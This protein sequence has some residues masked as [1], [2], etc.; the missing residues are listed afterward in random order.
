MNTLIDWVCCSFKRIYFLNDFFSYLGLPFDLFKTVGGRWSYPRGLWYDCISVYY[1]PLGVDDL[2]PDAYEVCINMSGQGCR[3]YQSIRG[4]NFD[5]IEWLRQLSE[6]FN[7]INFSRIDVAVDVK[8]D[9]V[10]DMIKII[11][12]V[13]KEKYV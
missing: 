4:D 6:G 10:P 7:D 2:N 3:R 13:E 1:K 8:D 12:Y 11:E 5:Y 9:T